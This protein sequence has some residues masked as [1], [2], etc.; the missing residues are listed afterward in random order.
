MSLDTVA[1]VASTSGA[2]D[3]S[4]ISILDLELKAGDTGARASS[5][6]SVKVATVTSAPLHVWRQQWPL[7]GERHPVCTGDIGFVV[8]SGWAQ[9]QEVCSLHRTDSRKHSGHMPN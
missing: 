5:S 1:H 6:R 4:F 9:C 7:C 8:S 2:G 3:L